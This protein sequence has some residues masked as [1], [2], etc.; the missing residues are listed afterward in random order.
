MAMVIRAGA[1]VRPSLARGSILLSFVGRRDPYQEDGAPG[2]LL[3]LMGSRRFDRV[4]IFYNPDME[5]E[6]LSRAQ[7]LAKNLSE[8]LPDVQWEL[9]AIPVDPP[10]DYEL[11]FKCMNDACQRI[12]ETHGTE[13][14]Y[15]IGLDSGTPQMQ[16]IWFILAQSN[17]VPATLLQGVPPRFADGRYAVREVKLTL[18]TFP[19]ITSP[20]AL[21]RHLDILRTKIVRMESERAAFVADLED[22]GL[23]GTHPEFLSAIERAR[24]AAQS[25]A[26]V[27]IRG[28]TGTGKERFAKIIHF[29]GSRKEGPFIPVNCAAI[30]HE[31]VESELF[32]HEAGAFTDAARARKGYFEL[33]DR[34]TLFLDEIGDMPLSAQAKVL[35]AL[36]EQEITRLGGEEAVPVDVRFIAASNQR[37]E[38][39]IQQGRFRQDLYYRLCVIEVDV[40][41]LRDRRS[42]I[43]LLAQY[44]VE[45]LNEKKGVKKRLSR[46]TLEVLMTHTWPG[47]VR[48]LE[49]AIRAMH[50]LTPGKSLA[51]DS[52]PRHVIDGV[53]PPRPPSVDDIQIP[54]EGF[55]LC[56]YL[57]ELERLYYQRGIQLT[58]GNMAK[59]ARLLGLQPPAFRRKAREHFHLT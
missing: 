56:G 46:E 49:N 20:D 4:C 32:G 45:M 57:C 26:P 3:S 21:R 30:P 10:T 42:D 58:D 51:L 7:D 22:T 18:D 35:R 50:D 12:L 54:P 40:P 1:E 33:A 25:E 37:L 13:A 17:L 59:A 23:V 43:A 8:R 52:L 14:K 11:L 6:F 55:D 41:A 36:E 28:E 27:V 2:P 34:G 48:Q 53:A 15:F 5:G 31:L 19:A 24:L 9:I 44:F 47:N 39:L 16:T 38:D 29:R